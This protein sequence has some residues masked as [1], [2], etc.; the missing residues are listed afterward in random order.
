M[1]H[2]Q[3]TDG[4]FRFPLTTRKHDMSNSTPMHHR[5]ID[6]A[7][8][9]GYFLSVTDLSCDVFMDDPEDDEWDIKHSQDRQALIDAAE[10]TD[11]ANVHIFERADDSARITVFSVIDEGIPGETINDYTI[12]DDPLSVEFDQWFGSACDDY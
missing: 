4:I 9:K 3:K 1:L 8:E 2:S 7:I 11:I 5:A 6:W 12:S 10:G